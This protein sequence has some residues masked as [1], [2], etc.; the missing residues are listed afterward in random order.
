MAN[1]E[2]GNGLTMFFFGAVLGA[3]AGLLLAPRSGAETREQLGDWLKERREQGEGLIG[4][5]KDLK[6]RIPA[7]KS[8]IAAALKAGKD[9]YYQAGEPKEDALNV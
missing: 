9:A 3:A 5:L 7:K 4:K 1:N 2:N 6:E 8:Q